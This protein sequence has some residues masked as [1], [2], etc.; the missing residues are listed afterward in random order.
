MRNAQADQPIIHEVIQIN[1]EILGDRAAVLLLK[2]RLE[3]ERERIQLELDCISR[4]LESRLHPELFP[5]RESD[6]P[7]PSNP[8]PQ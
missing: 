4:I 1:P 3:T 8:R 7:P 2:Q 5:T 6:T